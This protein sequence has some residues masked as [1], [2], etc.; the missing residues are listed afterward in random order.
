MSGPHPVLVVGDANV[1]LVLRGDVVP[2]FG[3]VEQLIEHAGL[4]L[5]GSAS[6]VAA[7][8]ARLGVP[9]PIVSPSEIW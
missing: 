8:L 4:V 9:T 2:R 7:G 5:G 6:I 3:Q 1:D